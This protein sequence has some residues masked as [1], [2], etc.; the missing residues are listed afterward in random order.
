M[1]RA[2]YSHG[3]VAMFMCARVCVRCVVCVSV[4]VQV[5]L[6]KKGGLSRDIYLS[7]TSDLE[8]RLCGEH[9]MNKAQ[10]AQRDRTFGERGP[11]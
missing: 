1:A 11:V 5:G 6:S 3:S 9:K 4:S 2:M 7:M 10:R 8:D